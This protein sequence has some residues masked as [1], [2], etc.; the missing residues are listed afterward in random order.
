MKQWEN[1]M[2]DF[3]PERII[4]IDLFGKT[5]EVFYQDV[6]E[7]E[8]ISIQG[9]YFTGSK[10]EE[11]PR[12]DFFILDSERRVALSRRKQSE[13]TFSFNA[14]RPGQYM[15]IFS[16]LK[17]NILDHLSFYRVKQTNSCHSLFRSNI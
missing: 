12:V 6:A 2:D 5:D 7:G 8:Q 1:Q 14:T 13:G 16:N 3:I 15:L 9:A 4:Q 17:V 10:N 11:K